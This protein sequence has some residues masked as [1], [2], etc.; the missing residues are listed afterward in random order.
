VKL[1]KKSI[2]ITLQFV[3]CVLIGLE[4][5]IP[6]NPHTNHLII[7]MTIYICLKHDLPKKIELILLDWLFKWKKGMDK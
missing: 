1:D 6:P 5:S 4:I 2:M 3:I 7:A